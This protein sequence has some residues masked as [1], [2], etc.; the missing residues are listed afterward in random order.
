MAIYNIK[1]KGSGK[2]LNITGDYLTSLTNNQNVMQWDGSYT[3]EQTW[4]I[5]SIVTSS[6]G[7]GVPIK[8]H[9]NQNFS[10]NI[11]RTTKN[12]DVY[13]IASNGGGDGHVYFEP[14]SGVTNGY[15]IVTKSDFPL[16]SITFLLN[17]IVPQ[18]ILMYV[19]LLIM[20]PTIRFGCLNL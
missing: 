5:D 20:V 8:S 18:T 3:P 9:V 13:P 1:N 2:Y 17:L 15:R 14:V 10:L 7:S 19:G 16:Q 12:A 4:V 6:T 11:Y